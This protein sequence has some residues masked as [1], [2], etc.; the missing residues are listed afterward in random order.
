[1]FLCMCV[2][3]YVCMYVCT[4]GYAVVTFH[5]TLDSPSHLEFHILRPKDNSISSL[6]VKQD[7]SFTHTY[8]LKHTVV[9]FIYISKVQYKHKVQCIHTYT[10][11]WP[12]HTYIHSAYIHSA[13]RLPFGQ[14]APETK[15]MPYIHTMKETFYNL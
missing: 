12:I 2:C 13:Y 11:I 8:F 9:V 4:Y 14:F 6:I 15:G 1:M 7:H 3:M 10:C 5:P